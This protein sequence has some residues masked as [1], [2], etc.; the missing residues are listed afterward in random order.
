[1]HQDY[2]TDFQ[3]FLCIIDYFESDS[4]QAQI[5]RREDS[6]AIRCAVVNLI[7]LSD[8]CKSIELMKMK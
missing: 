1:M 5:C 4:L 7:V 6:A 3:E 8:G 2:L